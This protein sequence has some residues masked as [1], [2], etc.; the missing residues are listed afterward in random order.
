V[1]GE[2]G[3]GIAWVSWR[4]VGIEAA[5]GEAGAIVEVGGGGG[6]EGEGGVEADVEGVA[7]VVI[8]GSVVG[9]DVALG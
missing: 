6:A 2:V 5:V 9:V 1:L 8:D 3:V 7:L 4:T